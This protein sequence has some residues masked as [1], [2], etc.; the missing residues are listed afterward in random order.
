VLIAQD[1]RGTVIDGHVVSGMHFV[2]QKV[3]HVIRGCAI[4][5]PAVVSS[6]VASTFQRILQISI[7]MGPRRELR[8]RCPRLL[9]I[10][11]MDVGLKRIVPIK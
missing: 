4:T 1:H 9:S 8:P 2:L 5:S 6:L 3:F 10:S 7:I 11:A